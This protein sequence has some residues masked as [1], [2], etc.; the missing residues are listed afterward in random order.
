MRHASRLVLE[1]TDDSATW[2]ACNDQHS[3]SI[4]DN[5]ATLVYCALTTFGG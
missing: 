5:D 2:G 4:S 1:V 3:G